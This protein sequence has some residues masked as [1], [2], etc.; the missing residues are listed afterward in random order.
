MIP[1]NKQ[2]GIGIALSLII[3]TTGVVFFI[4][5]PA[6]NAPG[7]VID[8]AKEVFAAWGQNKIN[9]TVTNDRI[10]VKPIAEMAFSKVRTRSIIDYS[11][12]VHGSTKRMIGHQTF[13]ARF[14]WDMRDDVVISIDES[15][16]SVVI[17]ATQPKLLTVTRAETN[18]KVL[19]REG[20]VFNKLTPEDMAELTKRLEDQVYSSPEM[21]EG[22]SVAKSSFEDYL[23]SLFRLQNVNVRIEYKEYKKG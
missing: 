14:G 16:R 3:L 11:S 6:G 21:K 22:I 9:I 18:P 5:R 13:E 20:G 1:I 12:T 19:F 4:L 2:I 10:E 7:K 8:A 17:S 15:K 23:M